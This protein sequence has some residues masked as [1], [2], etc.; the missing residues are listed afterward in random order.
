MDRGPIVYQ[1]QVPGDH[2][3]LEV[4]EKVLVEQIEKEVEDFD[5]ILQSI[6]RG[7]TFVLSCGVVLRMKPE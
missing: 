7:V 4:S 3:W 5:E 1:F 6:Q 2:Y